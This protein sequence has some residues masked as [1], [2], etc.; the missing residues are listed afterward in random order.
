VDSSYDWMNWWGTEG[1]GVLLNG[2]VEMGM[3]KASI[4]R[5][6]FYTRE[7]RA[8]FVPPDPNRVAIE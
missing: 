7:S 1:D 5:R 2:N 3:S 8:G 6:G 4:K